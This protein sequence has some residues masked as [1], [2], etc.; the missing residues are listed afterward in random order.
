MHAHEQLITSFYQAFARRDWRLMGACYHRDVHF[1]DPVFDL[2]GDQARLMWQMLCTRG[3]DLELTFR[4]VRA[5][6]ARGSAH[7]DATYTFSA[8]GRRVLNRIDAAFTFR[9]GL[10]VRHRDTFDFQ[11]W[12]RQALGLAGLLLGWSPLLRGSVRAQAAKGLANF[13]SAG[14]APSAA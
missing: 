3:R 11:R 4:D 10:I 8:T 12:A 1:S 6:A 9:D 13:A 2:H 5:D 14:T 7:W